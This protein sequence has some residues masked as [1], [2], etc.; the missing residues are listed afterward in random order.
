MLIK[1]E[2][3]VL[4]L[5]KGPMQGLVDTSLN[6]EAEY[7]IDFSKQKMK[8]CLGLHYNA[9]NNNI[10]LIVIYILYILIY[11]YI[12]RNMQVQKQNIMK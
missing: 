2:K 3:D 10:Y 7:F 1:E 9:G 8:F 5:D 12:S 11:I 4:I 6:A